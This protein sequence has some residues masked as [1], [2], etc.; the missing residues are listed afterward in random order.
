[1]IKFPILVL[2]CL[3][4]SHCGKTT[5][6]R[7]PGEI[8]PASAAQSRTK[9]GKERENSAGRAIDLDLETKATTVADAKRAVW[10]K[11]ILDQVYCVEQLIRYIGDGTTKQTWICP[12][13]DSCT[14]EGVDCGKFTLTVYTNGGS[15]DNLASTSGCK[16]GDRVKIVK[17]KGGIIALNEIAI[18][19]KKG[20]LFFSLFKSSFN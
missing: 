4:L 14:C 13:E 20:G 9:E 7:L 2:L 11:L 19:G 12:E 10:F 8:I 5:R 6:T 15:S 16:Y 17:T 1:M 18:I 3:P